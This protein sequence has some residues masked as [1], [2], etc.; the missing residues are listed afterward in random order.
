MP[1]MVEEAPDEVPFQDKDLKRDS[2]RAVSEKTFDV[3]KKCTSLFANLCTLLVA[4]KCAFLVRK[5]VLCYFPITTCCGFVVG[6]LRIA[7]RRSS[8]GAGLK[9]K[10][11]VRYRSPSVFF[12]TLT[13]RASSG[14]SL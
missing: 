14:V 8:I 10:A 9:T 12:H 3:S 7:F 11:L 5:S 4:E 13:L 2:G 1:I 6:W